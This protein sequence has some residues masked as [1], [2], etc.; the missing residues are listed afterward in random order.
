MS[1]WSGLSAPEHREGECPRCGSVPG[2]RN[3]DLPGAKANTTRR[4]LPPAD[5]EERY[6][7]TAYDRVSGEWSC[8][9]CGCQFVGAE[10][11]SVEVLASFEDEDWV[12][13]SMPLSSNGKRMAKLQTSKD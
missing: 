11:R 3:P 7:G 9:E 2:K 10:R 6:K 12:S 13:R 1:E 4:R 8:M 5:R